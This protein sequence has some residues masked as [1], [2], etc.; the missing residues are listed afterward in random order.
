MVPVFI[1]LLIYTSPE[2]PYFYK[3]AI[4]VFLTACFT[5]AL[6]GYLA[7]RFNQTTDFGRYIDPLADK[8]LLLSGFLC[9]SLIRHL[10]QEAHIPGWVTIA[11][12]ARDAVI[13][14]GSVVLY[15]L[16]GRINPTPHFIGKVTTFFQMSTLVGALVAAPVP[17]QNALFAGTFILTLCSGIVYIELGNRYLQS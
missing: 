10:P 3:L 14:I 4:A 7:R 13:L 11:V 1:G 6:D 17:V 2:R 8:M 15:L 9:L 16:K 5:D 12:I